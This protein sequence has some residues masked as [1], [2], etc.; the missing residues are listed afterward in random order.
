MSFYGIEQLKNRMTGGTY[1]AITNTELKEI[2]I[3]LP[4]IATQKEIGNHILNL[5]N[6]IKNLKKEA[7]QNREQAI[8]DF[9][10]EIFN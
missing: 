2:L 5:K 7:K 3:P 4:K 9:E 8:L 10:N 6:E 1:P